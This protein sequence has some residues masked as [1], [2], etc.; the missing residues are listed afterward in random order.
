MNES[1]TPPPGLVQAL[2]WDLGPLSPE[3]HDK[4]LSAR[5]RAAVALVREY[6]AGVA[7]ADREAKKG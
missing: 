5:R 1:R 4:A 7:Q 2:E 3:V 6:R